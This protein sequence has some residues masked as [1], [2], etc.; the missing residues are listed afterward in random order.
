M[1]VVHDFGSA[2]KRG[3]ESIPD[4]DHPRCRALTVASRLDTAACDRFPLAPAS[5][6]FLGATR[7]EALRRPSYS[8]LVKGGAARALA[9]VSSIFAS[10]RETLLKE[11]LLHGVVKPC[12]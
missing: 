7:D 10:L 9:A 5:G 2:V 4:I 3:A 6:A 12:L 11:D 1:W 8:A